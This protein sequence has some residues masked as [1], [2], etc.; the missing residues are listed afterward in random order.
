M[1]QIRDALALEHPRW[2]DDRGIVELGGLPVLGD[3]TR[4]SGS[5]V[6]SYLVHV[7]QAADTV[8]RAVAASRCG[9]GADERVLV[10][11]GQQP[12]VTALGADGGDPLAA[13]Q[14]LH[15]GIGERPVVRVSQRR[16]VQA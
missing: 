10:G 16:E 3:E 14:P 15:I 6:G 9:E 8:E 2:F 1:T 11:G 4:V 12:V 5:P 13:D 7:L